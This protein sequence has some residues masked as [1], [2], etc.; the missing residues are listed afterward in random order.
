MARNRLIIVAEVGLFC[1]AGLFF[2]EAVLAQ[3]PEGDAPRMDLLD[4]ALIDRAEN[5]AGSDSDLSEVLPDLERMIH[6]YDLQFLTGKRTAYERR[7]DPLLEK[8]LDPDE[9]RKLYRDRFLVDA[10]ISYLGNNP[11]LFRLHRVTGLAYERSGRTQDALNEYLTALRYTPLESPYREEEEVPGMLFRMLASFASPDRMDLESDEQIQQSARNAR[12]LAEE[13]FRLRR[14]VREAEKRID[15]EQAK[16]ARNQPSRIG[17]ATEDLERLSSRLEQVETSIGEVY[18]GSYRDYSRREN[19]THAEVFYRIAGMVRT[20]ELENKER[21]RIKNARSFLKGQGGVPGI[22]HSVYRNFPGYRKWMELALELWPD[23]LTYLEELAGELKNS[24]KIERAIHLEEKYLALAQ[25]RGNIP[26]ETL[27]VHTYDLGSMYMEIKNY[28]KAAESFERSFSYGSFAG[29]GELPRIRMLADLHFH[30]TGRMDRAKTLYQDYLRR[31]QEQPLPEASWQGP[32][33]RSVAVYTVHKNVAQIYK[34]EIRPELERQALESAREAFQSVE[35]RFQQLEGEKTAVQERI[36]A[37]KKELL[38]GE[39]ERLQREYFRALR[40]EL[41]EVERRLAY[42]RAKRDSMNLPVLLERLA[43]L[44][45]RRK[46]FDQALSYYRE[47][48]ARGDG[49][50]IQR[51][52]TN[53]GRINSFLRTGSLKAPL[54]PSEK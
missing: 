44:A 13:Y 1:V 49:Q 20:L 46:E 17:A 37:M 33:D 15:V 32:V 42:I 12:N 39:E 16:A 43:W 29:E 10:P 4:P 51:A 8:R 3:N 21:T 6:E 47:I 14:E 25:S 45:G 26:A 34:T 9:L 19:T 38:A 40:M 27:A 35:T 24:R 54:L 53:I 30:H 18:R 5:L 22:N 11:L 50:Q 28:L 36:N 7:V 48:V 52:R 2:T 23:N 41:P 31:I